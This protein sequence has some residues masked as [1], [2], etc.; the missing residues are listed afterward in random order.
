MILDLP[1]TI[2]TDEMRRAAESAR[3]SRAAE[4]LR[5]ETSSTDDDE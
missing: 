3:A 4:H 1:G 2:L 5:A